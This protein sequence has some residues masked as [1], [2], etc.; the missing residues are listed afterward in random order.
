MQKVKPWN[1]RRNSILFVR[2]PG[3]LFRKNNRLE[4]SKGENGNAFNFVEKNSVIKFIRLAF[5][6]AY[7]K[8][9]LFILEEISL[10]SQ[11]CQ[12]SMYLFVQLY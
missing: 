10:I 11:K 2:Y 3:E 9:K 12:K 7:N 5:L 4:A 8:Y 6:L 1:R